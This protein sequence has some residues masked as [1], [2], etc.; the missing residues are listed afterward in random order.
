MRSVEAWI[1]PSAGAT[2][3]NTVQG[4]A[5]AAAAAEAAEEQQSLDLAELILALS[6]RAKQFK[7][8]EAPTGMQL[9]P[10]VCVAHVHTTPVMAAWP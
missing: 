8:A 10:Q 9:Q 4:R 5:A 6:E 1:V 3:Q 2:R 7:T